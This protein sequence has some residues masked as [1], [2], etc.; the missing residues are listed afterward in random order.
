MA[1]ALLIV[2]VQHDFLPGGA[3]GVPDGDA[4]FQPIR[5]EVASGHHDLVLA[6][7]DWHPLDHGSFVTAD[8]P[9]PWPVHCVQGTPGA[10]LSEALPLDAI[11]GVVDKGEAHDVE[12]YSAFDGTGLGARLRAADVEE[13][14]VVGLATDY[15]VKHSALDALREGFRVRV[16]AEATRPVE[17][18]PG[19]G[20]RAL[21][22]VR[23]AGGEVR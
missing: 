13:V 4:V 3:L 11:A 2:D 19:D 22:E 7:R 16:L 8:P 15:C 23:A 5:R 1:R 18:Q 14:V 20:E 21:E 12:G 9:G 10:E 17:R 6:T